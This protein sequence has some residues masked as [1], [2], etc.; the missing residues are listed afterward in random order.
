MVFQSFRQDTTTFAFLTDVKNLGAIQPLNLLQVGAW[1]LEHGIEVSLLDANALELTLP[2][3][4]KRARDYDFDF[5]CF[6]VTNLDYL[7][8]IEWIRAFDR[9]FG[10][11]ILVGGA[12]VEAYPDDVAADPAITTAFHSPA[13]ACLVEWLAAYVTGADWWTVRGTCSVHEGR[14]HSNPT[15]TLPKDFVRPHPARQLVDS[16][17][18]FTLLSGNRVFTSAMSIIGCPYPCAFCAE[19]RRPTHIRTAEDVVDEMEVCEKEFGITE[20]DYFDAGFTMSRDRTL[21]IAELY[22]QRGLRVQWSAR[23]RIDKVDPEQLAAMASINCRWLGYGIESA[24]VSVLGQTNKPQGTTDFFHRNLQATRDVGIDTTGFFVLGLPGET[25]QSLAA[26]RRFVET[27][28]LDYVQIS[29]Y[30]PVPRTPNYDAIVAQTGID[31]WREI[32]RSGPQEMLPLLDSELSMEELHGV[33]SQ[34]YRGFYLKPR[35]LLKLASNLRS[36][37]QLRRTAAA[38][39]DVLKGAIPTVFGRYE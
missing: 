14:L 21:R 16:S 3:A 30:W 15:A 17:L 2:Q 11:P 39:V 18:Y 36:I 8:A 12:G 20:I 34:M 7:F 5:V 31:T 29:P 6:T 38:G 13:E 1:M 24:D 32:I 25:H 33:A 23:V 4:L 9:E 19:R 35:R 28:P 27:A 22:K 10:K 37:P 26:T